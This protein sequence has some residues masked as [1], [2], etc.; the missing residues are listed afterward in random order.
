MKYNHARAVELLRIGAA[1]PS[2]DFRD[3]QAEAIRH[4]I[5]GQGRLLVIQKTGWGKSFVYFI[6]AKLMR[7]Q[8]A[9]PTLL[10]SPLL[11]LMRNQVAAAKAMGV[12]AVAINSDN[13]EEWG[14]IIE[15]I[16][17]DEI[18]VLIISPERLANARFNAEVLGELAARISLLVVDEAHCISDWG[19]DFRPQY[20]L[21]ERII[22]SLPPNLRLLATTATANNRVMG[23]LI[24][25]LG[26]NLAT[27][28]GD[29][30][31][32]SLSLQTI[33]LPTQAE[34][35]AWIGEKLG[36]MNG[37]GIIYTLTVRDAYMLTAWLH[38][39]GHSVAC[40][41]GA[42]ED[43]P[44][45]ED[46][47]LNNQVK[48]LVA[49]TALGMGYDK[50]DLAFVFHFQMPSSVVAYYQQVG[51]AGRS[52]DNA[53]GVLLSGTEELEIAEW[54][55]GSAFPTKDEVAVILDALAASE[56]GLSV[57]E[58][59]AV[60]NLSQTRINKALDLLKLESPAP[61]AKVGSKWTL[62]A[63]VLSDSFWERTER[64]TALRRDELAEM[65][66]YVELPYGSHMDYLIAALDGEPPATK[67][68]MLPPLSIS[69]DSALIQAAVAFLKRS[70]LPI[71][72]RQK[73]PAGGLPK[74]GVKGNI[75]EAHRANVGISL[76]MWGDAGWGRLVKSDRY[77]AQYFSDELVEA[78]AV[79]VEKWSPHPP[80]TW[81]TAIPSLR[82]P[83]LV[84]S[85][86]ERL[87]L[88]LGI[89]YSPAILKI[90][91]TKQQKFMANSS[92][93]ALNLDGALAVDP[94]LAQGGPVLLIDDIVNSR[95]TFT[96]AAMLLRQNGSGEVWPLALAQSGAEE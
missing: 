47:L 58:L 21:L 44:A 84:P 76:S 32:P 25:V 7:E 43:R 16:R 66:S 38:S 15:Q 19:H 90:L 79:M 95:W 63:A 54:F 10:I 27:Y 60:V 93:Q 69:V 13:V 34:R 51:R 52:L 61:I 50:P 86:A 68:A 45:L 65:R 36:Q 82:N 53:Y 67:S 6:A 41:T 75:A 37:S 17:R 92:Q 26:P 22:K 49:T 70:N 91:N 35:M 24:N 55:I 89:P 29:L 71:Q 2:A 12:S 74:F 46:A 87:A 31:R 39:L 64:L 56:Q 78:C 73:W 40:Y 48:A 9:G 33:K 1:R 59:L 11:S 14:G 96:V 62:T 8:G 85:F 81:V 94:D 88:R 23:D 18:D 80:P 72:P 57:P 20:R 30:N 42:T 4:L 5:E 83:T 3:G 77:N 28:K